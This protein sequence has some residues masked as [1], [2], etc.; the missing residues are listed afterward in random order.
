LHIVFVF[1]DFQHVRH[2]Q[3]FQIGREMFSFS[4]G[5][6]KAHNQFAILAILGWRISP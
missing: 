5:S 1:S 3:P 2:H 4:F 6:A